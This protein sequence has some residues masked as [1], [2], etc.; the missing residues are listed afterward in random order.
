MVGPQAIWTYPVNPGATSTGNDF[1]AHP[2]ARANTSTDKANT[3]AGM[4][5]GRFGTG[6]SYR[7]AFVAS[8]TLMT[9]EIAVFLQRNCVIVPGDRLRESTAAQGT[10]WFPTR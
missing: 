7:N 5:L 2:G 9:G 10:S 1:F 4:G 3:S 6:L 8:S